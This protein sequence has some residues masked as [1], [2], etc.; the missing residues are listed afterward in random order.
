MSIF[1]EAFTPSAA[2]VTPGRPVG[3]AALAAL[4][5][6]SSTASGQNVTSN[7]AMQ[8]ST[9]YACVSVL[10]KFLAMLPLHI[11]TLRAD[12]GK[13]ISTTHRLYKLLR[14]R[15]NRWMTSFE[16]RQLLECH[17]QLRGNAYAYIVPTAGNG[18]SE[19]IPLH[20]DMVQPFIVDA[21]G[22]ASYLNA[23]SPTPAAGSK[24]YYQHILAN[25]GTVILD[26]DEIVHIK[27]ISFNGIVGL[28]A[29]EQHRETI[30]LAMA[31]EEHGARLFTNGAQIGG[32]FEHPGKLSTPAHDHL[33]KSLDE[34]TA[35][36]HNAHKTL[37]LEEGMKFSKVGMTG[38]DAQFL[39][40]RKYQVEDIARIF[41]VP[42]VLIGHSG[43]KNATYASA[44]QFFTSFA[45]HTMNPIVGQWEQSLERDLLYPSELGLVCVD[46]DTD[47]IMRGDSAARVAY[48][49][50]RFETGSI[51]PDE[52]RAKEGEN[53]ISDGT[54]NRYYVMANMVRTD[55]PPPD[56]QGATDV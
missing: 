1:K 8:V 47:A 15:P 35:G 32:V 42:L 18:I 51:C 4:F 14:N 43:D 46:F 7:T 49:K 13:N 55:Q 52:I 29:I 53:A 16:F 38:K 40:T 45:T 5:G 41:N 39:E 50:G 2:T 22:S 19:L 27:G 31:T 36:N 20:P 44:E 9:V 48:Y 28:N 24:L 30:G 34:K 12:G 25:G 26:P 23:F 21:N 54:G 56:S 11:K 3:D 10:S 17:R 37:I 6:G 33:K